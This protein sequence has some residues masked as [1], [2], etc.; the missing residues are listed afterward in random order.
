MKKSIIMVMIGILILT[1]ILIISCSKKENIIKIGAVLPLSGDAAQAGV[2]TKLGIDLRVEEINN[3]GGIDG[4]TLQIIYE[5]CQGDPKLAVSSLQKLINIDKV[6]AV[7]DNSLSNVTLAM[8]PIANENEVVLLATGASSPKISDAGDYIFRIWN[9]DDLE[10]N[11]VAEYAFE[12]LTIKKIALFIINN[13]YGL[14]LQKVFKN[15]FIELGGE[16]ITQEMFNAGDKDFKNQIT[17]ILQNKF[18]AIYLVGYPTECSGV[19]KQLKSLGFKG[20]IIGTIVMADPIVQEAVKITGYD[21]YYPVPQQPDPNS[22]T[23]ANFINA[24]KTKYNQEPPMLADVG[25]DA[26]NIIA[27]AIKSTKKKMNGTVIKEY[28]YK[29]P[30][31]NGASG[32]FKFDNNGDVRKPITVIK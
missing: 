14:G 2:N 18:E 32:S 26:I 11:V 12:D 31:Y 4:K 28:F 22:P 16:V 19:I 10:G 15:K 23:V 8:A 17:K 9:S 7:I 5:D 27:N 6:C 21:C 29:M 25:Y 30:E 24:F 3:S 1:L 20:I 13:D